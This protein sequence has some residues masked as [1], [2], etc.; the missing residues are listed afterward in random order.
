M[1]TIRLERVS[2]AYPGGEAVL[3]DFSLTIPDRELCVLVGPSG[4]GKT[5]ILRLIAGL[6]S[7]D[8]GKIYVGEREVQN[9]APAGR[10]VAMVFQRP[11]IYPHLTVAK[12]IAFGLNLGRSLLDQF[13][14]VVGHRKFIER[15]N[16]TVVETAA[17][18][19]LSEALDRLPGTLSGGQQQ[20]LALG[21]AIARKPR[22][23]L[24]D[25]P[26]S[27]LD[28]HLRSELQH[29][30]LALK[31][32]LGATVVHVTHDAQEAMMLAGLLVVLRNGKIE[33]M[34]PPQLLY[35]QPQNR[36][37]AGFVGWPP[38]NFVEGHLQSG[39]NTLRWTSEIGPLLAPDAWKRLSLPGA[40]RRVELGIRAED[41][42]LDP[43]NV[44]SETLR[45]AVVRFERLG[46]VNL[47]TL[48]SAG[49]Q[50]VARL[51]RDTCL[52][53]GAIVEVGF[54]LEKAHLFDSFGNAMRLHESTA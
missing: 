45:M 25:E 9:L 22:I 40:G 47:G 6:E 18:L 20:R 19:G 42:V 41:L 43:E 49:C 17:L 30:I 44:C 24:L 15:V 10:N 26:F 3:N 46:A 36:F 23:L 38:M 51:P 31:N 11:A 32:R 12:N 5:T 37:V 34:G 54:R 33:Q 39:G 27:Q 53:V 8:Q 14:Y 21:R 13:Q 52:E 2:K 4:S 28:T 1:D 29:E 48:E 50:M 7:P 35:E 16:E